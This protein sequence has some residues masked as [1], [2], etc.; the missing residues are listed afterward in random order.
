M[1]TAD[2]MRQLAADGHVYA[3][4]RFAPLLH[5]NGGLA[6][7]R[8]VEIVVEVAVRPEPNIASRSGSS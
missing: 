7:E 6:A 5:T 8:V 3:E 4:L 1:V 2:V